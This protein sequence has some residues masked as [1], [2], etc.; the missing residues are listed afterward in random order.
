M[1][2]FEYTFTSTDGTVYSHRT[3]A[4]DYR[5]AGIAMLRHLVESGVSAPR[6]LA[7]NFRGDVFYSTTPKKIGTMDWRQV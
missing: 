2:T 5:F 6:V 3:E 4:P 1:Q 7:L